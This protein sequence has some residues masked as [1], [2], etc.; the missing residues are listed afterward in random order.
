MKDAHN[1]SSTGL[2]PVPTQATALA[3]PKGEDTRVLAQASGPAAGTL[4]E[5]ARA[6]DI[7]VLQDLALSTAL[8]RL[9]PGSRI[10]ESVFLAL[11]CTLDFLLQQEEQL[12]RAA[13]AAAAESAG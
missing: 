2:Q 7:P 5:L 10:P 6:H 8:G 3:R 11:G 4:I 12:D 1:S 9:P 13:Q